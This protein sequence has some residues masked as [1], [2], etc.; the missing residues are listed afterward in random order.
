M[1]KPIRRN[2]ALRKEMIERGLITPPLS[3]KYMAYRSLKRQGFHAAAAA[4][5]RH[6][7]EIYR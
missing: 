1:N 2:H 3:R 7:G 5:A 6:G 4:L